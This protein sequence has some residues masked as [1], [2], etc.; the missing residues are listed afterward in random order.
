MKLLFSIPSGFHW[1]ELVLPLHPL[2]EADASIEA[3]VCVTPAAGIH[4]QV[5][6][7]YSAKFSFV[8][9]KK[10]VREYEQLLAQLKP[11]VVITTTSGLDERDVPLLQA[12][13][14][15][16]IPTF[17]FIASW[18][19]VWK[20]ERF[21]NQN[22]QLVLA[23]RLAV[24]NTMMKNHLLRVFP[25]MQEAA[26]VLPGVP[27]FDFF[28]NTAL[29]PSREHLYKR[30]GLEDTSRPFIHF[31]TT[32]LY[33]MDYLLA[34]VQ[35]A[36]GSGAIPKNPYLVATVHPGGG[37]TAHKG[38]ERYGA[39]VLY[40]FGRRQEISLPSFRYAPLLDDIYDQVALFAQGAVLVNHSS[41]TA[42]ESL[43]VDVPVIN[44]RYGK[45]FDWW[46]WYRS[47]V[48]RDFQQHYR[49]ITDGGATTIVG[50]PRQLVKAAANALT[51]PEWQRLER[52]LTVE[53]MTAHTG[54]GA[55][56]RMLEA[57]KSLV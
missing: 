10:D 11:D 55:S 16:T 30:L 18:D 37:I 42:I 19:N 34:A 44:V 49:D 32:E 26:I 7:G 27:R 22:K 38:L 20:M 39:Q 9:N 8:E 3:V 50:S 24:W 28:Y 25:A 43:L 41:T 56:Q 2:L 6:T 57:I 53:K 17:T 23:D 35:T 21:V 13:K 45:Q 14:K 36:V 51:H 12:A 54:G 31:S 1:R 52:Q 15:Q 40:A 4:T 47:M 46:R 48:Y 5:F 33:P 29:R